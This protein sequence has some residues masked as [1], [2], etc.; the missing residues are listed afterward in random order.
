[1]YLPSSSH[2]E[3]CTVHPMAKPS[4]SYNPPDSAFQPRLDNCKSGNAPPSPPHLCFHHLIPLIQ[5]RER[6]QV[7][8][9]SKPFHAPH[10][11][12]HLTLDRSPPGARSATTRSSTHRL[13]IT[14]DA[15]QPGQTASFRTPLQMSVSSSPTRPAIPPNNPPAALPPLIFCCPCA[16]LS[17]TS[18]LTTTPSNPGPRPLRAP[19]TQHTRSNS[20]SHSLQT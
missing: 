10:A 13:N 16:P 18:L 12:S 2:L 19:Y 3:Y 11:S 17:C 4:Y 5:S 7:T 6:P 8:A 1:M 20:L 9:S 15:L 14:H